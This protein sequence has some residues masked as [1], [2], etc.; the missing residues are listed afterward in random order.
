MPLAMMIAPP[1]SVA[2]SGTA[3]QINQSSAIPQ[4]RAVYSNGATAD[5][6][7]CRNASVMA[8]WPKNPVTASAAI[9]GQCDCATSTHCGQARA[10]APTAHMLVAQNTRLTAA[11]VRLSMRPAIAVTAYRAAAAST[12]SAPSEKNASAPG[13]KAIT[14][15]PSPMAI[16]SQ[17]R[18]ATRS[19]SI[20]TAN[21]VISKGAMKK[22]V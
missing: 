6:L 1:S 14:T 15:P 20:G 2:P 21:I 17:W 8:I 19:L 3:L 16:A 13:R 7:P 22:M 9:K 5:A 12:A 4:A 10:V 11:S 18:G